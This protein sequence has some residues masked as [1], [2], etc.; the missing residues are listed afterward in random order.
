MNRKRT[1]LGMLALLAFSTMTVAAFATAYTWE[2]LWDNEWD[3]VPDNWYRSG[4]ADPCYE[5]PD[6]TDDSVLI[7]VG[8]SPTIYPVE[9]TIGALTIKRATLTLQGITL[10]QGQECA[11]L[12]DV[13]FSSVE[14]IARNGETGKFTLTNECFLVT[15]N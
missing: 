10:S 14:I 6:G 8:E 5:Y 9:V 13:V 11:R 2:G 7:D 1:R 15:T 12:D 3:G 4:C